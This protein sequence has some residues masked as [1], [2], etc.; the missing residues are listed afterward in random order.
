MAPPSPNRAVTR[1]PRSNRTPAGFTLA[2]AVMCVLIVGGM[3]VASMTALSAV[4]RVPPQ[5]SE[6]RQAMGLAGQLMAEVLQC[7]FQDPQGG[8]VLGTDAGEAARAAYDDVDDYDRWQG[9]QPSLKDGTPLAGYET[10]KRKVK[11][12]Y[13]LP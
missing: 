8:T 1:P 6:R 5:Q 12:D 9:T 10:W 11:V 2:E 7:A 3:M 13:V 4:A